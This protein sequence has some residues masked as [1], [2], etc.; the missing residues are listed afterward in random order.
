MKWLTV[1]KVQKHATTPEKALSVTKKHWVQVVDATEE[2]IRAFRIKYEYE[3]EIKN[4]YE[5][6]H[7]LSSG[8]CGL[9]VYYYL[10]CLNCLIGKS[11]KGC[12]NKSSQYRRSAEAYDAWEKGKGPFEVFN[13][14]ASKMLKIVEAVSTKEKVE[15]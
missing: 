10:D 2:E 4:K 1:K 6:V 7:L 5:Q 15:K 9:C 13:E 3:Y 12:K 8:L 14:E 11:G